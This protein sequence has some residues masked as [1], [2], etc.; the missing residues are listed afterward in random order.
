MR[1][2][3]CLL[4]AALA[5][6]DARAGEEQDRFEEQAVSRC[7]QH[8]AQRALQVAQWERANTIRD[9][10]AA[11]PGKLAKTEPGKDE[12]EAEKWFELVAGA[13]EAWRKTDAAAAGLSAMY[14]RWAQRLE[15]GPAPSIKRDEFLTLARQVIRNAAA[16]LA[17]GDGDATTGEADKVFRI[18]DLNGDGELTGAELSATLKE[19]KKAADADGDGRI[20]KDE[21]RAYFRGRVEKK[22]E[23]LAAVLK[24]NQAAQRELE[25]GKRVGG[26]PDWFTALDLDKDKQISLFE[27]RKGKRPIATFQE[28]D[29]NG[30]GLLTA[31]EYLRWARQKADAEAKKKLDDQEKKE[32]DEDEKKRPAAADGAAAHRPAPRSGAGRGP[33]SGSFAFRR[34]LRV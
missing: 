2:A 15:L 18:L 27:W 11:Y 24:A 14:E 20:S 4:G 13:G 3:I 26:L 21:Y 5:G 25:G 6:A 30:D 34:P 33:S 8:K 28:M 12:K 17:Q 31:D 32:R 23:K 19:E 7:A 16:A 10:E 9:L 22:A 1:S 29:L